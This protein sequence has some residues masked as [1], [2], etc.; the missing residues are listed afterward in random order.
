MWW[1]YGRLGRR[2][3]K[4]ILLCVVFIIRKEFFEVDGNYIGFKEFLVIEV[5]LVFL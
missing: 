3:R 4:I 1:I 2:Y 5:D